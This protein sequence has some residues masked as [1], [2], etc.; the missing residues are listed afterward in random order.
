MNVRNKHS[1]DVCNTLECDEENCE[2]RH[3]Y[4]CK[5]DIRCKYNKKNECMY[6]HVTLATDDDK[7]ETLKSQFDKKLAKLELN[8]KKM[9]KD[10]IEKNQLITSLKDEFA[11]LETSTTSIEDLKKELKNKTSQINSLEIKLEELEKSQVKHNKLQEKKIKEM[12]NY[13]KQTK[14]KGKKSEKSEND[15]LVEDII[16]CEKCDYTTTS[17]QGLKIHNAKTHSKIDFEAFPAACNVCEQVFDNEKCL[18]QRKRKEHTFH[19]IQFQCNECGFMANDPHTMHIH[20]GMYHT[21]TLKM[22]PLNFWISDLF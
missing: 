1:D 9:E 11:S 16:K 15:I 22:I 6:L 10:L 19:I 7:I 13:I 12:E 20:F 5:F 3:P 4:E 17:R 8:V 14:G 21:C 18:N 2:K